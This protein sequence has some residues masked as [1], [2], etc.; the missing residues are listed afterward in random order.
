MN[1][2]CTIALSIIIF[3]GVIASSSGGES[4]LWVLDN[5]KEVGGH[6][7][8]IEGN[9]NVI[10]TPY[11]QA[12]AFDGR[13]DAAIL[14]TNPLTG[15]RAFTIEVIFRPDPGGNREQRFLHMQASEDR[16]VLI[17]TRVND[18]NEWFLDTFI[19]C[20]QSE[21]TLQSREA[22]HP[23]SYTHLTLPTNREV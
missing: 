6:E 1:H 23:V 8:K 13:D 21:R 11:G 15:A 14:E 20:G 10:R 19:K 3:L 22:L 9:P 12:L 18:N 5:L 2:L 4:M 16:R 7:A 17:E